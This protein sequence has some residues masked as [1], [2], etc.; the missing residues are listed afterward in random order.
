MVYVA[1]R[2]VSMISTMQWAVHTR[3]NDS[4][5]WFSIVVGITL[6]FQIYHKVFTYVIRPRI[7]QAEM[8]PCWIVIEWIDQRGISCRL[9]HSARLR[10][11]REQ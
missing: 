6:G 9:Y 4:C 7:S 1:V 3:L 5:R 11:R 10:G 2:F 8:K